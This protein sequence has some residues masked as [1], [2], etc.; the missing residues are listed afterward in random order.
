MIPFLL[1]LWPSD[2]T[3]R[4]A[5]EQ[6]AQVGLTDVAE[7]ALCAGGEA[8]LWARAEGPE[9]ASGL[10]TKGLYRR[11]WSLAG[12]ASPTDTL[13]AELA[14]DVG[15]HVTPRLSLS[16]STQNYL[17]NRFGTRATDALAARDPFLTGSRLEYTVGGEA[18][19]A[20]TLSRRTTFRLSGGYAQ[21]GG[22]AA[23]RPEAVGIDTH[24]PT[25]SISLSYELGPKDTLSPELRYSFTHFYHALYDRDLHRG[26]ADIHA[27][28]ATLSE[29]RAFTRRLVGA[30]G[31]G[32]TVSTPPP[33]LRSRAPIASPEA[34]ISLGYL[35]RRAK[36]TA[37]YTYGFTSLGPRIGAGSQHTG[38]LEITLRPLPGASHRDLL[39]HGV[40]R[41]SFGSAPVAANPPLNTGPSPSPDPTGT[42]TTT[43]VA[44]VGRV[45]A[46]L[47]PGLAVTASVDLA[48]LRGAFDPA[49]P[50]SQPGIKLSTMMMLGIAGTFSTD[51][52]QTIRRDSEE[53]DDEAQRRN[54]TKSPQESPEDGARG[55]RPEEGR[56]PFAD[57]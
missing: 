53:E 50:G 48:L 39:V 46:P 9:S 17:A 56:L 13:S 4:I 34:K 37:G 23:S 22:L 6:G 55:G 7:S 12:G 15:V 11:M 1:L 5:A 33:I 2:V 20:A 14:G 54:A 38:S 43:T 49:P 8:A 57:R 18:G 47:R 10:R 27:V 28:T 31:L 35:A 25:G 41:A 3:A 26:P 30:A 21:A 44:A 36:L 19:L 24:A 40:I 32:F 52:S 45:E 16:L 42:V 29:T 51:P